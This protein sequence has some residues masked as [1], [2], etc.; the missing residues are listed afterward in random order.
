MTRGHFTSRPSARS[1]SPLDT[2]PRHGPS[3]PT[4]RVLTWGHAPIHFSE[5]NRFADED[6][7]EPPARSTRPHVRVLVRFGVPLD[8]D[9]RRRL[10]CIHPPASLRSAHVHPR[11]SRSRSRETTCAHF[12]T[13]QSPPGLASTSLECWIPFLYLA[14]SVLGS[15]APPPPPPP[16]PYP[17]LHPRIARG[18]SGIGCVFLSIGGVLGMNEMTAGCSVGAS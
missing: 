1:P 11:G 6:T 5:P 4:D 18:G 14:P 17:C 7:Y 2:S 8:Q 15:L 16:R 3:R 13:M 10:T 9:V 12:L